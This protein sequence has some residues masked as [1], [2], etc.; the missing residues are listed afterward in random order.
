[1]KGNPKVK[2]E[3]YMKDKRILDVGIFKYSPIKW[4][5]PKTYFSIIF[6]ITIS[7]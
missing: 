2:K 5:T 1:M 6:C 7:A 3:A 4:H